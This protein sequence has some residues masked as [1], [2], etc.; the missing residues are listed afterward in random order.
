MVTKTLSQNSLALIDDY[1][2]FTFAGATCSIPYFNNKTTKSRA[3]LRALIG[4]GRPEEIRDELEII[5]KKQKVDEANLDSQSLKKILVDNNLGI[6]CSGF[7]FHILEAESQSRGLGSLTKN[8]NFINCKGFIGQMRCMLRPVENCDVSTF[9]N[10]KNSSIIPLSQIRP[11][12]IITMTKEHEDAMRNHILI[13]KEVCYES[14]LPVSFKYAHA[15]AYPEDGLY[16]SQIRQGQVKIVDQNKD[17]TEQIW[18]EEGSI[19]NGLSIY[20][21]GKYSFQLRKLNFF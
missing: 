4:K 18:Q 16:G 11:G 13:I 9:A 14:D 20:Y 2:K 15:V 3:G 8:I 12:D 17:L 5:I 1:V 7:A 19:S 21:F 6:E 10:N